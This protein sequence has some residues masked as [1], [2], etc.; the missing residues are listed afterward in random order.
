MQAAG[1][2]ATC[3]NSG[4]GVSW[5]DLNNGYGTTQFY[6]GVPYSGGG[7]YFGGTQDN[8]T[9]RGTDSGGV[10]DWTTVYGGDG[11]VSRVDPLDASTLYFEYV[12]LSLVKSTDG[13][14][15]YT[16]ATRGITESSTNFPFI[17]FYT[18]DPNDSLRLYMGGSQLWRSEDGGGSWSAA[19][20]AIAGTAGAVQIR[21][22]AV[23]PADP[24]LVLFG[25]NSGTI[26]RNA[27]ALSATGS[28]AW[29]SNILRPGTVSSIAFDPHQPST[30]YA[31]YHL[32]CAGSQHV[33]KSTGGGVHWKGS[34]ARARRVCRTSG[35]FDSG[36]PR[37]ST[38]STWHGYRC[39][40][41]PGRA[42]RGCATT[43]PSPMRS[44]PTS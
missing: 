5:T 43:I 37:D 40:R 21:R 15:N 36:G 10:N 12:Y 20:A 31:T 3:F 30:V 13:G 11:G 9:V 34:M 26:Y 1:Q 17:T 22:I 41:Q 24:N 2:I 4:S 38:A 44:P 28:T 19:S 33:Y 7:A 14:I 25:D 16:P 39:L 29:T 23:S 6:H 27:S 8:G 42:R 32:Q 35:G 18:F